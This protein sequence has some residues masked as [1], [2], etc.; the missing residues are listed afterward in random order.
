MKIIHIFKVLIFYK[1]NVALICQALILEPTRE[2]AIQTA[3]VCKDLGAHIKGLQVMLLTGG[4]NAQDDVIRLN[5]PVHILVATPGRVCDFL[6]EYKMN[7]KRILDLSICTFISLDEADKLL[8]GEFEEDLN[9]ILKTCP[10]ERQTVLFSA[11]FPETIQTFRNKWMKSPQEINLMDELTL[12]GV[13]QYFAYV[14]EKNKVQ[15][16]RTL[17][18]KLSINQCIIFCN[19]TL[20][21]ELL[22]K[23]ITKLGFPCLYMHSKMENEERKRVFHE[24]RQGSCRNLVATD[25]LTRGID[26]QSINVVINYDFP[27]KTETYLHRIGRSGRFGHLG[28][29]INFI[30]PDD[31]KG[32]RR[33]KSEL[34]TFILP[35]PSPTTINKSLYA[36]NIDE[37]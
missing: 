31:E 23:T 35:I 21:V 24:F 16:V 20:R 36:D 1:L 14:E 4:N 29:A 37:S 7:R 10:A 13:T 8:S 27:K 3:Q 32:L 15:S 34:S 19:S 6:G 9:I 11:T 12:K 26:V 33:I 18:K 2:L 25:L 17:L 5:Q 28:L 30:T 22:A